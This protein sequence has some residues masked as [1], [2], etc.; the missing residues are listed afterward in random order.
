ML[1][2]LGEERNVGVRGLKV[3]GVGGGPG[4]TRSMP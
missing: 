1:F 3:F 4:E 2:E